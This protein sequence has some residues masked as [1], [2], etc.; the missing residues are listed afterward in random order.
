[1]RNDRERLSSDGEI[2]LV[3]CLRHGWRQRLW[4]VWVAVPII[5]LGLAYV[6]LAPPVYEARLYIQPPSRNDIAPLNYGRGKDTGLT[7]LDVKDVYA[8]YLNALHSEA[9]RDSFFETIS[10]R[11]LVKVSAVVPGMRCMPGSKICSG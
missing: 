10:F 11:L 1:M 7:P 6:M 5:A 8:Y 4:V 3:E 2:D 9:V